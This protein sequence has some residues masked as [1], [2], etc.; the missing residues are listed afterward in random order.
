MTDWEDEDFFNWL[1]SYDAM[2][3]NIEHHRRKNRV[4]RQMRAENRRR[5]TEQ[6]VRYINA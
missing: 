6:L 3:A 1:V 5:Q 2:R 4:A